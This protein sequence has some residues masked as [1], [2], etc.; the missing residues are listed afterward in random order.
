MGI[1]RIKMKTTYIIGDVH[2][3]YNTL[4]KLIE[5]L[6]KDAEII[7]VGDLIDRGAKS[8]Q[9]IEL[10]RKNNYRC[11]L[12]NHEEFM[13]DY[14]AS[15]TKSYPKSTNAS[16]MHTWYNNGGDAT[17]YSYDL[18]Q[19][20][21]GLT[22]V[23]NEEGMQQF[24]D[25][26]DEVIKNAIEHDVERMYLPNIDSTSTQSMNDLVARFPEN[27]FPMMGLH[28]CSVKANYEEELRHVED[29][30]KTGK[31]VG[32]GEIGLDY[33]W[34]TYFKKEQIKAYKFQIDL[35]LEHRLP[36]IIHSRESLDETIRIVRNKQKGQLRGIFH[37]FN[38]TVE[39]ANE[40]RDIGFLVGLGGVSTY[41]KAD[42][43]PMIAT[44]NKTDFVLETDAPYLSPVP[45]RGK[46][47][48]SAYLINTAE[49]VAEFMGIPIKQ[50]AE[51]SSKNALNLFHPL[52]KSV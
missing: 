1:L 46:R 36:I 35:A 4:L 25:D 13:I 17:L 21:G 26:I 51:Y 48:E 10:I 39:Q 40:I 30:L 22:C 32:V 7:F 8:R 23:E 38:G 20:T 41:K 50:V 29:E 12:G 33:Y 14:G 47:N 42:L 16:Y 49:K 44:L 45:F 3:E 18:I 31:Y 2:G 37:C 43:G 34:D 6:P 5:K 28:P 11:V 52:G 19:Y 9:V 15:F 27:C 24:K